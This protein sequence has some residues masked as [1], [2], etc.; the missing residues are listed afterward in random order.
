[1]DNICT[2][3]TILIEMQRI[4]TYLGSSI[5][6]WLVVLKQRFAKVVKIL[7]INSRYVYRII[8]RII[9]VF[10]AEQQEMGLVSNVTT[11]MIKIVHTES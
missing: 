6:K 7:I 11:S 5:I 2:S 8:D 9:T 4:A 1:M 10:L 3:I